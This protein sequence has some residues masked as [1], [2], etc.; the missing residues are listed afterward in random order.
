MENY[1]IGALIFLAG[2][3][4]CYFSVKKPIQAKAEQV[5]S[6]VKRTRPSMRNPLRT[7]DVRYDKYKTKDTNLYSPVKPVRKS[8]VNEVDYGEEG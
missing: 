4:L 2:F 7:Y 5:Y 1:L 3:A 8:G 6:E